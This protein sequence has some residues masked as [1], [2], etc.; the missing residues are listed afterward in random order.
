VWNWLSTVL[1][2]F[3]SNFFDA[4]LAGWKLQIGL[5]G[6]AWDWLLSVIKPFTDFVGKF[7]NDVLTSNLIILKALVP[8][9]GNYLAGG[10]D[11]LTNAIK[12]ATKFLG[13]FADY[14]NDIIASVFPGLSGDM[15]ISGSVGTGGSGS[16]PA[17]NTLHP[18]TMPGVQ[19]TYVDNATISSGDTAE[20]ANKLGAALQLTLRQLGL[21]P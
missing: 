4:W 18:R 7:L 3:F 12:G 10:F 14:A 11:N 13:E 20:L 2:P 8:W 17:I 19:V 6:A 15:S 9:V 1:A 5:F 16:L 21:L